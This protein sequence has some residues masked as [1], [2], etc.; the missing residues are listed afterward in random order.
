MSS[1]KRREELLA[2]GVD[3]DRNGV[4]VRR[5]HSSYTCYE[6]SSLCPG[7]SNTNSAAIA[8]RAQ[9]AD[10][11]VIAVA[12]RDTKG[13]GNPFGDVVVPAG[14]VSQRGAPAGRVVE[15]GGVGLER[16]GAAGR[17]A[18]PVVLLY[19]EK[20]PLAVLAVPVVLFRKALVPVAVSWDPMVL[21]F[22]A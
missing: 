16:V 15:P 18:A 1:L 20:S 8:S 22:S 6:E 2:C 17:V 19:S 5:R 9:A 3:Q 11:N 4:V 21:L 7:S 12:T 14:V 10:V 13:C